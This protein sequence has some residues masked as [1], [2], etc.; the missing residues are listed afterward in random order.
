MD[1]RLGESRELGTQ[2]EAG[3][4]FNKDEEATKF[5]GCGVDGVHFPV[6]EFSTQLPFFVVRD[7]IDEMTFLASLCDNRLYSAFSLGLAATQE[8]IIGDGE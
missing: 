3:L 8:V 1:V 4:A 5:A 6:S 2:I 7:V